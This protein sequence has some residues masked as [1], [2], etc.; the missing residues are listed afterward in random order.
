MKWTRGAALPE[1][2]VTLGITLTLLFGMFELGLI[3]WT[4]LSSDGAAFVAAHAAVLGNDPKAAAAAPFPQVPGSAISVAQNNADTTIVPVDF[5]ASDPS[6]RHGGLQVVRPWHLQATV[7]MTDVGLGKALPKVG[8]GSGAIEGSML[9]SNPGYDIDSTSYNGNGTPNTTY[10]GDDGNA[11]PYF[12]G[13]RLMRDCFAVAADQGCTS[14]H[15]TT[16]GIAEYLDA[17]NWSQPGNGIGAGAVYSA[18][19]LHQN[20]YANIQTELA[21]I[22]A[23]GIATAANPAPTSTGAW[24]DPQNDPCIQTVHGWDNTGG[25]AQWNWKVSPLHPTAPGAGC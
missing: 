21:R 3:G 23:R 22:A 16:L 17:D 25:G 7:D 15:V 14:S 8:I 1:T 19:M 18:M 2:A 13:F 5:Q 20:V 4:Q 10:F 24:F 11:P 6:N 9:V 12:I